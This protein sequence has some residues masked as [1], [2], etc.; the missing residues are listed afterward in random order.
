MA[1]VSD[2]IVVVTAADEGYAMPL[3]VM[4]RSLLGSL[5][6]GRRVH[7]YVIADRVRAR[8]RRRI[9]AS[10]GSD[11][12]EVTWLVPELDRLRHFK[13]DGHVR[14]ATYFRLLVGTLLPHTVERAI[15]LDADVIVEHDLGQ[16]WQL[17]LDRHPIAAAQDWIVLTVSAPNGLT[18]WRELGLEA[19]Q[20]YFNAGVMVIDLAR[21]RREETEAR[22]LAHLNANRQSVRWW[23]Q[24]GLNAVLGRD[25][26]E[27]DPRWNLN[28]RNRTFP[29]PDSLPFSRREYEAIVASPLICHFAT[30][31]KPWHTDCEHP[32]RERF[33]HYLD[34]TA[35]AGWRPTRPSPQPGAGCRARLARLAA[36][37]RGRI[38]R[39]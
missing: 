8:S 14:V 22:I 5:A 4:G 12:L 24:D 28:I 29:A 11:R 26:L 17:D 32:H 19:N 25:F 39:R 21:W 27:L 33:F 6:P 7:L 36:R 35:W 18:N 13:V 2:P 16:L 15:Y 1:T 37:L 20:T 31:V 30:H 34:E 10:W 9:L 38:T 3:A 23:D